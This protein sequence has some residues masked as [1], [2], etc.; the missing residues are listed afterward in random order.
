MEEEGILRESDE[1]L[2]ASDV[3]L[4]TNHMPLDAGGPIVFSVDNAL[5]KDFKRVCTCIVLPV[6]D[7]APA[8]LFG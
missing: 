1:R 5:M 4:R 2:G 8:I 3:Q 7:V 6:H